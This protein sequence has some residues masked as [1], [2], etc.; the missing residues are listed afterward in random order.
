MEKKPGSGI[1]GNEVPW[2]SN[3]LYKDFSEAVG[4][5]L[6]SLKSSPAVAELMRFENF[7][8]ESGTSYGQSFNQGPWEEN[9]KRINLVKQ[10]L[11]KHPDVQLYMQAYKA[12]HGYKFLI[13]D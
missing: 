13:E 2:S 12:V 3:E 7:L 8:K 1:S 5:I 9:K 11:L 10:A 4:K 6:E